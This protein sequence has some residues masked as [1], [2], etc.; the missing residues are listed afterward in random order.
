MTKH[1]AKLPNLQP[2]IADLFWA[3]C[4]QPLID[5]LMKTTNKIVIDQPASANGYNLLL[6][7][8]DIKI[9]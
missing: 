4:K 8:S 7:D 3:T 2:L 5:Y 6:I 9:G 1:Y